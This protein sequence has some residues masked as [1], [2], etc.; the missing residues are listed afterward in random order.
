VPG[1]PYTAPMPERPFLEAVARPPRKLRIA[2]I[3]LSHK[4]PT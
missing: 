4:N 2:L 1:D 3:L